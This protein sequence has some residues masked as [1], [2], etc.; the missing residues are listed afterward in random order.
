MNTKPR[1]TV[2]M[3]AYMHA[4]YIRQALDA[5][6]AQTYTHFKIVACDDGSTD[7]TYEILKEY[8]AGKLAGKLTVI[9]HP[10]HVNRGIYHTYNA[11]LDHMDT[12]FFTAHASDDFWDPDAL[13]YWVKFMD[14]RPD[15]DF[16]YGQ[17]KLV[18][19]DGV[20]LHQF[21]GACDIGNGEGARQKLIY[22]MAIHEPTIF[23]RGCCV[24]VLRS[25][26]KF[27]YGD[28]YNTNHLFANYQGKHYMRPCVNYRIHDTSV[29][30][31]FNAHEDMNRRLA[32]YEQFYHEGLFADH[33][34]L[35]LHLY[36]PLIAIW[37]VN[38][39]REKKSFY[40]KS[41]YQHL[42]RY[43]QDCS[44]AE[45]L[46]EAAKT[47][48]CFHK[49]AHAY[50]I[51]LLPFRFGRLILYETPLRIACAQLVEMR[52][53]ESPRLVIK[54]IIQIILAGCSLFVFKNL[55]CNLTK[56]RKLRPYDQRVGE[57]RRAKFG[58]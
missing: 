57:H 3:C 38:N 37:T 25:G 4:K 46:C 23:Y 35:Q 49:Q 42:A 40:L 27:I 30:G 1:G 55:L 7:G 16:I 48:Y 11:C 34:L 39:D 43:G 9:T 17:C 45:V 15:I 32:I 53:H 5:L 44:N 28:W 50:F 36:F 52:E 41:L 26:H 31:K 33:P 24:D 13:E 58:A 29:M 54:I 21:L 8:E 18:G 51:A 10:G 2:C 6:A 19:A 14:E 56:H 22:A 12:E 20:S 47:A